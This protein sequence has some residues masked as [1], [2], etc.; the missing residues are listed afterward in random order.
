MDKDLGGLAL[1]VSGLQGAD[2]NHRSTIEASDKDHTSVSRAT[3]W[4]GYERDMI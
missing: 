2:R 1:T 4:L 3:P